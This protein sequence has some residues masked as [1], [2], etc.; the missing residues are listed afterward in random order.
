MNDFFYSE[1]EIL[2]F[3][4]INKN[5]EIIDIVGARQY[6]HNAYVGNPETPI[7]LSGPILEKNE[8]YE[9]VIELRTLYDESNWIF[10]L[11]GF[12]TKIE[13]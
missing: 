10:S 12:S 3:D 11:Y 6:D 5:S 9:F 7:I 8:N 13:S 2:R 1:S 4:I